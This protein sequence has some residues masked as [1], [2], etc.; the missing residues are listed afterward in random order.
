MSGWKIFKAVVKAKKDK[1]LEK[2]D[3]RP[4]LDNNLPL[5]IRIG[6]K[7]SFETTTFIIHHNLLMD[8][9][10][11]DFIVT[12]WEEMPLSE[13][14]KCHRFFLTNEKDSN[15]IVMLQ[16]IANSDGHL[17]EGKLFDVYDEVTPSSDDDWGFWLN[18]DTG[19]IGRMSFSI[20]DDRKGDIEYGRDEAW[21]E[22]DSERIYPFQF[23]GNIRTHSKDDEPT[24]ASHQMMMYGRWAD[25]SEEIAEYCLLSLDETKEL[26][27]ISVYVGID[28]ANSGITVKY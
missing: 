27:A 4:I 3:D 21:A 2:K 15:R 13:G 19:A 24:E 26:S 5:N 12:A 9:P 22:S 28:M 23:N 18:D 16:I 25:E 7:V 6:S 1:L 8:A 14:E 17:S 11:G 10:F 20:N